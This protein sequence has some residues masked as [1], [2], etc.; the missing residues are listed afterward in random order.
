MSKKA[1]IDYAVRRQLALD[2]KPPHT[3]REIMKAAPA[4]LAQPNQVNQLVEQLPGAADQAETNRLVQ[5]ILQQLNQQVQALDQKI[6][7]MAPP[8]HPGYNESSMLTF[9]AEVS[10]QLRLDVP[11][12]TCKWGELDI[13]RCLDAPVRELE[14]LIEEKTSSGGEDR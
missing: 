2:G 14:G 10:N 3:Y 5:Q 9:L 6:R 4:Q 11:S 8:G 7:E 1:A 13:Q 12:R